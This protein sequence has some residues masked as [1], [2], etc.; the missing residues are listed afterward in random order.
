MASTMFILTIVVVVAL[1]LSSIAL[2]VFSLMH[3]HNFERSSLFKDMMT[4][5]AAATGFFALLGAILVFTGLG[6]GYLHSSEKN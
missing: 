5:T 6:T 1:H 4:G 3:V 2:V